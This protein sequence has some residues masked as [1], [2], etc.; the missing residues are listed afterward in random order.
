MANAL[1]ASAE[2]LYC[3]GSSSL[4]FSSS[5]SLPYARLRAGGVVKFVALRLCAAFHTLHL[6][7]SGRAMVCL[8]K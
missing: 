4:S 6:W 7:L 5:S 8:P 2:T 3:A 1:E